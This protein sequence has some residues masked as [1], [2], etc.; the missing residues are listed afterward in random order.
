MSS[1]TKAHSLMNITDERDSR[2]QRICKHSLFYGIYSGQCKLYISRIVLFLSV[3]IVEM[4]QIG[5]SR[6]LFLSL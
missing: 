4:S 1:A 5:I 6:I 3:C 2:L